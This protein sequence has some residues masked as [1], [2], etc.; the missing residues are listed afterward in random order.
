MLQGLIVGGL[1]ASSCNA[2][3]SQRMTS[4]A[5]RSSCIALSSRKISY[6]MA[7]P[8]C[9]AANCTLIRL[10]R[11]EISRIGL[12]AIAVTLSEDLRLAT[13]S[14]LSST[15]AGLPVGPRAFHGQ[16]LIE[17]VLIMLHTVMDRCKQHVISAA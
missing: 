5:K 12:I 16:D 8:F 17:L 3:A 2:S 15:R 4:S 10:P 1:K 9:R 13:I 6:L 7:T 11:W 14:R